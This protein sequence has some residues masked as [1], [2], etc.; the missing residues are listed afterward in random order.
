[1]TGICEQGNEPLDSVKDGPFWISCS[2][3]VARVTSI[4]EELF[5]SFFGV[6]VREL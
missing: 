4:S 1:V 3:Q 2:V 6:K 5:S